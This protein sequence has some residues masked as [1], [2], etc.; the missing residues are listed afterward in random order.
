MSERTHTPKPWTYRVCHNNGGVIEVPD[1]DTQAPADD[2]SD[3]I[4]IAELPQWSDEWREE[5]DANG[6]LMAAA[7]DLLEALEDATSL[8]ESLVGS[9]ANQEGAITE[10]V[11]DANAAIAKARGRG[12]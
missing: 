11:H 12:L 4:T 1:P 2:G 8:L 9:E 6:R 10:Q 3:D 5:R 7:P